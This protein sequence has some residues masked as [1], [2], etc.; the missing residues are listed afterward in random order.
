MF[1]LGCPPPRSHLEESGMWK[2]PHMWSRQFRDTPFQE[3]WRCREPS[4]SVEGVEDGRPGQTCQ[5]AHTTGAP[6]LQEREKSHPQP[7]FWDGLDIN[8]MMLHFFKKIYFY[9][10]YLVVAHRIFSCCMW[11][12]TCGMWYLVPWPGIKPRPPALVVQSLSCWTTREVSMIL[13]YI[14][15]F[16]NSIIRTIYKYDLV[17]KIQYS[18][19]TWNKR[20]PQNVKNDRK[21][22]F[23]HSEQ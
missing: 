22:A 9:C 14:S 15:S 1:L 7:K 4:F 13:S 21:W 20:T 18:V 19:R 16:R 2:K 8:A 6:V 5:T 10:I 17:K 11:T 3:S 12:L 23:I